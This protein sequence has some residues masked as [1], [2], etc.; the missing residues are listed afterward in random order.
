[1]SVDHQDMQSELYPGMTVVVLTLDN[2]LLFLGKIDQIA[3]NSIQIREVS[4]SHLPQV[5]YNSEVKLRG[6]LKGMRPFMLYG[7]ICGSTERMWKVDRLQV[8]YTEEKRSFFRQRVSTHAQV[9]R[10]GNDMI[11]DSPQVHCD[12]CHILDISIGGLLFASKELYQTGEH[13]LISDAQIVPGESPFSFTCC[14]RRVEK[15]HKNDLYG[16]QFEKL[17][18]NEQD[19]ILRALFIA[20]KKD[21][22]VQRAR[23][24]L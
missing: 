7:M 21:I 12:L 3:N 10:V 13:L 9:T 22:Q 15:G 1:M 11:S 24:N 6:F 17:T 20:Q 14:V 2:E 16:C 23:E 18:A 4:G 5:I 8:L 19:R